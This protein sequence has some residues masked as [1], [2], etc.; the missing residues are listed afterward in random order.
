MTSPEKQPNITPEVLRSHGLT[1]DEYERILKWL[2]RVPTMT[3]LGIFSVMWSEH[4]SYKS[5]RVHLKRLPTK[6]KLVMQGPGENA[7]IIDIGGEWACAFKI[8]SHNH[9]SYIEPF[10]GATT[11][12][13][14]ILRDIFTMGARPVAV[15]DS[16]RF[17]PVSKDHDPELD[18]AS[19]HKNHSV[20]DG[21][22]GGV[23]NYGNCFGVPNVGG[24]VRFEKCYAGNPLVNAF[25]L[26]LVKKNE[27][28]YASASGA[29]N[30]VIYVG[31]KTGK[32]GIHGAT[33]ASEEFSEE[34]DAKRPNVQVGDPFMEKLLLEAC[35]E[36]MKTGAIVGIQDMG[37]AGLTCSTCELGGRGGVGLEIEL[38]LVPQ[39]ETGMSSYEIMLSESQ[40]RML[41]VAEKGR[42]EEV[43]AVFRKW[44]LD[45][46]RVGHVIPENTMRV[47]H[48]GVTV[49]EIPN[50]ALTDDAPLYHREVGEWTAPVPKQKPG[51]LQLGIK[52]NFVRDFHKLLASPNI[53]SKHWVYEQYDSMVQTNTAQGP[54][55]LAGLVRVKGT[56]TGLAMALYGNGRWCYLDPKLGAEHNVARAARM[57]ACTGA[58]PV[59]TTDC[60]N[61]GNPEKPPIMAQ[62]SQVVDGLAEACTALE[63]PITGGN[64]S[65]YNET[66][67]EGIYPTP[68]LGIVG[69]L[70]DVTKAVP[71][72]AKAAGRS[73]VLLTPGQRAHS[74]EEQN[75]FG[76]SEYALHVL[77]ELWGA[78][79]LLDLKAE[80]VLQDVLQALSAQGLVESARDV[81]EG[82][83]AVAVAKIAFPKDLGAEINLISAG[84]PAECVLFAEDASRALVTCDPA[85]AAAV[86]E[87][88]VK[89]GLNAQVIGATTNEK[90]TI[91]I[92]NVPV[93]EGQVSEFKT[94]WREALEQA[95][96]SEVEVA[97]SLK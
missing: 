50:E 7:G 13:G 24:E 14:G 65:F 47:L 35:L 34:S 75:E 89:Y 5:S 4:C 93:I 97:E 96:Q 74:G 69:I 79:P 38:D 61:F 68:V 33:M 11:G 76:S 85:K 55:E 91:R 66:L 62:F 80:K 59:A 29:G 27:I 44:G 81:A 42:E 36:A 15:M 54:G 41:L 16:L 40:E 84:L 19:L 45:A 8:E 57:V 86:E 88:A 28:F 48:H 3:E 39:R 64:V 10:Q 46:V 87:T 17:G 70:Q 71:A 22:V 18:R 9:P 30:S 73:I 90:L 2:G 21:V 32:D 26:G 72:N 23:A 52:S 12:V 78:P 77:G 82:G 83:I 31:S 63:T 58:K 1:P 60:L 20:L 94:S 6:S 43:F 95:L 67:G 56:Q 25:A 37:A 51:A 53:C 92:D 49:A